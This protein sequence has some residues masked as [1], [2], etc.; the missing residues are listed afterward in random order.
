MSVFGGDSWARES[1]QRKRRLDDL[2][3][4]AA[5]TSSSSSSPTASGSFKRLSSGKFACLVCPH[6]PVLDSSLMLS[7][8]FDSEEDDPNIFLG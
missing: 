3:L 5:A 4:P 8:E 1:Q 7:V 2:M 6:R